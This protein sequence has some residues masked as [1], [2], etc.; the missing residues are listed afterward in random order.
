[1]PIVQ[2]RAGSLFHTHRGPPVCTCLRCSSNP[3][4]RAQVSRSELYKDTRHKK[5]I[6]D[7][8]ICYVVL[9]AHV[10]RCSVDIFATSYLLSKKTTDH[11]GYPEVGRSVTKGTI[12]GL[13]A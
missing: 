8:C 12:E 5:G 2:T 6:Q 10:S 4:L 13:T 9:P 3:W 11:N 1:M 7:F